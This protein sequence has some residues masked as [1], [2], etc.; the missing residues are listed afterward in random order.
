MNNLNS[1]YELRNRFIII[2]LTGRLG[3]GC[4]TVA[5]LITQST[6]DNCLFPIPVP[7]NRQTNEERKYRITYN[8]LAKNWYQYTLIRASDV[9]TAFLLTKDVD[10]ISNYLKKVYSDSEAEIDKIFGEITSDFNDLSTEVKSMFKV[11]DNNIIDPQNIDKETAQR[12]FFTEK[13]I[14]QFSTLLKKQFKKLKIT[15]GHYPFQYFGDNLRKSGDPIL[16]GIFDPENCYIIAKVTHELIKLIREKNN[17]QAR[18]VVDSIRNSMEA[19]YFKERYSAFYL[20]AVNTE[21]NFRQDRLN[22]EFNTKELKAL[23]QEY[24]KDLKTDE[25]FYKQDIQTC[26]QVADVYLYNPDEPVAEG[27]KHKTLKKDVLR[28][29]AL[30]LQPGIIT[31]TPEERCM[32]IAYTAKYNSGCI[33]RQVGAVVTDTFFFEVN[34]ME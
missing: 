16:D 20:F 11:I 33:S 1:L 34:W 29:L 12:L 4:T 8:Y 24:T 15:K 19:R 32:Q 9:I 14:E 22:N 21:E 27:E 2:G 3:S 23:D 26:I 28:Y 30:I 10:Q 13:R 5:N 17:N 25:R 6:F 18:I 31:P 7:S